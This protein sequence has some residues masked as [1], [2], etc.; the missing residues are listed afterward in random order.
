MGYLDTYRANQ[1]SAP[2]CT[3]RHGDLVICRESI[4]QHEFQARVTGRTFG[5]NPT[6]DVEDHN[7]QRF[8]NIACIRFDEPAMATLS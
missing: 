4:G 3:F 1:L 6:Y 8:Q 2:N 5:P 7:G